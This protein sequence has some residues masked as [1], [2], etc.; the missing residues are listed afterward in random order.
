MPFSPKQANK[1]FVVAHKLALDIV[2]LDHKNDEFIVIPSLWAS[3]DVQNLL[4]NMKAVTARLDKD[5]RLV[6]D[7]EQWRYVLEKVHSKAPS[8]LF[9]QQALQVNALREYIKPMNPPWRF[10]HIMDNNGFFFSTNFKSYEAEL[11][12]PL[13]QE[14]VLISFAY[15]KTLLE[16]LRSRF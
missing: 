8:G 3:T 2:G 14:D 16:I 1:V 9:T 11:D 15:G 10:E 13:S 12:A 7:E 5:L 6:P 4:N